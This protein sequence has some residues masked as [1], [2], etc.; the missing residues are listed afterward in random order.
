[1]LAVLAAAGTQQQVLLPG[2][3]AETA[4]HAAMCLHTT[5]S[6]QQLC[7]DVDSSAAPCGIALSHQTYDAPPTTSPLSASAP[8]ACLLLRHRH[9]LHHHHLLPLVLPLAGPHQRQALLEHHEAYGL[10]HPQADRL[11]QEAPVQR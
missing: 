4:L 5:S 11:W 1:M 7:T 8:P 2:S 3:L 9:P 6:S 10:A